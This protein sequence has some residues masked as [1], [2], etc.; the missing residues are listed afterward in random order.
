MNLEGL[1]KFQNRKREQSRI[2]I[3][4]AIKKLR[5]KGKPVNFKSVSDLSGISRKTLYKVEEFAALIK[6]ERGD[7]EESALLQV[8]EEQKKEIAALKKEIEE[9]K[10]GKNTDAALK[11]SLASLKEQLLKP[12]LCNKK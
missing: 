12:G 3:Q 4:S 5:D 7:K 11:E 2:A 10:K 6:D 8:I 1:K 9:L